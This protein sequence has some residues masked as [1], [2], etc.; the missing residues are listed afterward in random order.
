MSAVLSTDAAAWCRPQ[1]TLISP[2]PGQRVTGIVALVLDIAEPQGRSL[3]GLRLR[4]AFPDSA[5]ADYVGEIRPDRSHVQHTFALHTHLLANGVQRLELLLEHGSGVPLSAH[6]FVLKVC[7]EGRIADQVRDSLRRS[8]VP[9]ILEGPCDAAV[10]DYGDARLLPWFDRPDAMEHV[11]GWLRQGRIGAEEAAALRHFVIE[12]YIVLPDLIEAELLARINGEIDQAVAARYQGYEYGSSKRLEHL[13]QHYAGIRGLWLHEKIMRWME[14]LFDGPAG[15]CQT[16]TY[17]FGS[18][19]GIH[20]DTVHLTPFPAGYMCGV[21]TALEDVRPGSGELEIYPRS[22][23]LPRVYMYQADCKKVTDKD[24]NE[25]FSK[26]G[27]RW[28]AMLYEHQLAKVV[29][30]PKAGTVLIWHENLMH[31]GGQRQD[32]SLSRRSIV[33][34]NFA[35]GALAFYD[36][37]GSPGTNLPWRSV[38]GAS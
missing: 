23:R 36:T 25:F 12:G 2:S 22:H 15:V 16:L 13:H 28:Q 32:M 8:G 18:Q 37:T 31:A 24:W 29:Y 17:V 19:Q 34:H 27:G 21:W 26:V 7:N 14:L 3:Q 5:Y 38:A 11:E 1:L 20:Q 33:T 9:L 6:T 10:Y 35:A 30:K 4:I